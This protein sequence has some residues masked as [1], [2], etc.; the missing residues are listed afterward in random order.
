MRFAAVVYNV[1]PPNPC[2]EHINCI[3]NHIFK[4]TLF[5]EF[6]TSTFFQNVPHKRLNTWYS[7]EAHKDACTSVH[8]NCASVVYLVPIITP[9]LHT[10]NFYHLWFY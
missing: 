4:T 6:V 5:Q 8:V 9:I 3:W 2:V 7:D 10:P 1:V